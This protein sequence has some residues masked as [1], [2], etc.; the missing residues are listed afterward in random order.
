MK[1]PF[2]PSIAVLVVLAL[3]GGTALWF[4]AV[5]PAGSD[6]QQTATIGGPFTLV[7]QD[8]QTVTD[9]DFSGRYRLMFF[10]FTYCPDICPTELGRI[11]A[12]MRELP[13]E[14]ASKVT[15]LFVSVDPERDTPAV[16]KQ[17]VSMF[18][19]RIRAL[20]GSPE[21]VNA[22]T[23]SYRIYAKKVQQPGSETYLVDHTALIYLFDGNGKFLHFFRTTDSVPMMVESIRAAV[24][25]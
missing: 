2:L 11:S 4:V 12:V 20:T 1:L 25:N 16:L 13:P 10:G 3:L 15:P 22:V 21:Q 7:D 17:Y 8:G 9:R 14:V 24:Q 6:D 19:N 23:K 5:P 18:D